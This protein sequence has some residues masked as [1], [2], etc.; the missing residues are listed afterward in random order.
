MD[1]SLDAAF[2]ESPSPQGHAEWVAER[3]FDRA[4]YGGAHL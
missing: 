1:M 4:G 2:P 3:I